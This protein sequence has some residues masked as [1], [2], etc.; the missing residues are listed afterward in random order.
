MEQAGGAALRMEPEAAPRG[1][2]NVA[3]RQPLHPTEGCLR[4]A[5]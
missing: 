4:A 2:A 5:C 1:A 3:S